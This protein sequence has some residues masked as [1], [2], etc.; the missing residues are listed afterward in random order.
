M[1]TSVFRFTRWLLLVLLPVLGRASE[2]DDPIQTV[3][4]AAQEWVKVRTETTRLEAEWRGEHA[5]LQ[6]T[7]SGLKDRAN[8]LEE[9]RDNVKARTADDRAE[10]D[11]TRA[12]LGAET[13]E[14][15]RVDTQLRTLGARLITLRAALPP[16]LSEALELPYR[17]LADAGIG[18]GERMQ[19][20]LAVLNR[21]AQFNRLVESG[22]GVLKIDGTEKSLEVIYWGLSHGYALDRGA[23]KAW[24][25]A[26]AGGR[27]QWEPVPDAAE[28]ERLI[29]VYR[30]K[31]D[32]NFVNVPAHLASISTP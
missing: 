19:Y 17:S 6:S 21:C 31:A 9:K 26:P 4:R 25:G 3:E 32:P 11:G 16:R 22:E 1:N 13:A 12:K 27:W 10:I 2:T 18:V 15:A 23:H 29:A 5:L 8:S 28:V 14:L 24:L 7:I 20:V 30:D